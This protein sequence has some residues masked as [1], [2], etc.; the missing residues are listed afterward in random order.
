MKIEEIR[1]MEIKPGIH[2]WDGEKDGMT[3]GHV[4]IHLPNG[5][6]IQIKCVQFGS[7]RYSS[8]ISIHRLNDTKLTIFD[9]VKKSI[10]RVQG[11]IW[12]KIMGVEA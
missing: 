2:Q 12:T 6:I 8:E 10:R 11:T 5:T 4:D 3:S 9:K 1:N 7:G